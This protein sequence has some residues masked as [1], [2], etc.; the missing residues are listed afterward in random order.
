MCAM[1]IQNA[2][3]LFQKESCNLTIRVLRIFHQYFGQARNTKSEQPLTSCFIFHKNFKR[4]HFLIHNV[5]FWMLQIPDWYFRHCSFRMINLCKF[6]YCS[7]FSPP[8]QLTTLWWTFDSFPSRKSYFLFVKRNGNPFLPVCRSWG[9]R[10]LWWP[11]PSSV[12]SSWCDN[13]GN[14]DMWEN[15]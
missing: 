2:L 7:R 14:I 3:R 1:N 9:Q 10:P 13:T 8:H 4:C 15:I 5:I 11:P 6:S 12:R